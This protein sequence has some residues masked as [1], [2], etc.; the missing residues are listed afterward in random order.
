MTKVAFVLHIDGFGGA[1]QAHLQI[2]KTLVT[3][4]HEV[5]TL[6][7]NENSYIG[8]KLKEAGSKIA[9]VGNLQ[10]WND[11]IPVKRIYLDT[12]EYAHI[13]EILRVFNPAVIWTH[14]GVIPQGAISAMKL[15]IPTSGTCMSF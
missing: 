15:G 2:A 11:T 13:T 14:T 3:A 5:L 12:L 7:P 6:L 9:S 4:G 10:W 8:T 1:E